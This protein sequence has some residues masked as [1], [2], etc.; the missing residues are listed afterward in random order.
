MT[1][2]GKLSFTDLPHLVIGDL[3]ATS[4]GLGNT[5]AVCRQVC[6]PSSLYRTPKNSSHAARTRFGRPMTLKRS[7][8]DQ[9]ISSEYYFF[10]IRASE[11]GCP[12]MIKEPRVTFPGRLHSQGFFF[13]PVFHSLRESPC[14]CL[15]HNRYAQISCGLIIFSVFRKIL[16]SFVRRSVTAVFQ[17]SEESVFP[18]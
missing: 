6:L 15:V 14:V 9:T 16:R 12:P 2:S 5:P 8:T 11:V 13:L 7:K 4:T 3:A 10:F 1:L 17:D 18:A